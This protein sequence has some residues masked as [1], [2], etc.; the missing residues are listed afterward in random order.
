MKWSFIDKLYT[1][2]L[3]IST[4][5]QRVFSLNVEKLFTL[6]DNLNTWIH[7]RKVTVFCDYC[8]TTITSLHHHRRIILNVS[9]DNKEHKILVEALVGSLTENAP[10]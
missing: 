2:M 3:V 5:P 6:Y 7:I 8:S 9:R 1:R 4:I 10:F